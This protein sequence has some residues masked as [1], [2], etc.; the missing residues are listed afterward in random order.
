MFKLFLLLALF[1]IGVSVV[2][3]ESKVNIK[4]NNDVSTS[5]NNTSTVKND[6]TIETNGQVTHYSSNKPE[7]IEIN[8]IDGVSEIKVN[9]QTVSESNGQEN[10]NA[11]PRMKPTVKPE[12]NKSENE[13]IFDFFGNLFRKIF[14]L[15]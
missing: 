2:S 12:N 10:S 6:I 8:S 13:N 15:F 3:A 5:D 4:V 1:F 9:G 7:S 14:L 11:F